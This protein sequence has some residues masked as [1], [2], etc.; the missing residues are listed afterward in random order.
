MTGCLSRRL[1]E[2][3][4]SDWN[5]SNDE[6]ARIQQQ[7]PLFIFIKSVA[8]VYMYILDKYMIMIC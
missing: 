7:V 2:L 5:L 6:A 3:R 1:A 4:I 8:I